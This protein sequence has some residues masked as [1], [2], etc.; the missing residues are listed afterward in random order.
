MANDAIVEHLYYFMS[1]LFFIIF[2][3]CSSIVCCLF[4]FSLSVVHVYDV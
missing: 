2:V 4:V 1:L 3:L